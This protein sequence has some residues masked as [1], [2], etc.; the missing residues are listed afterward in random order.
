MNILVMDDIERDRSV[1]INK[2]KKW[3][4][5]H[6]VPLTI[7]EMTH[8]A[9]NS[10]AMRTYQDADVIF[11]DIEMPGLDGMSLAKCIREQ[12][13]RIEIVFISSH[14]EFSLHGYNVHAAD[15]LCK[16]ISNARLYNVLD[17]VQKRLSY[18]EGQ[19][20]IALKRGT[21]VDKYYV[22]DILYVKARLHTVEVVTAEGAQSY[23][24]SIGE[25]QPMLP[26]DRFV[27]CHRSCIVN[28][29]KITV[30]ES[31]SQLKVRLVTGE[32]LDIG[33]SYFESVKS[34]VLSDKNG[35]L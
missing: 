33:R 27:R 23:N 1:L 4:A 19:P 10:P 32:T 30:V 2:T 5:L 16:P 24:I 18:K 34:A 29:N 21:G 28:V 6:S 3:G 12:N 13:A 20:I 15:Y 8:A 14:S 35:V 22:S 7:Q 25:V 9:C 26:P 31:K 17:Y 11:L